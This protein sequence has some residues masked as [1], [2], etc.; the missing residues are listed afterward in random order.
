MKTKSNGEKHGWWQQL[1]F[2][3]TLDDV[4]RHGIWSPY[5]KVLAKNQ[6]MIETIC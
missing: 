6:T 3:K 2:I 5:N 4:S 1:Q